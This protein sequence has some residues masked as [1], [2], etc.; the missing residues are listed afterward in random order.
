MDDLICGANDL[1]EVI[2]L[3]NTIHS[4]LAAAGFVLRK[5]SS[6]SQELLGQIKED[7]LATSFAYSPA[8][9]HVVSILGITW[10][11]DEDQFRIRINL[12]PPAD[13]TVI[14]K[15][16]LLSC[17]S[18]IFDPLGFVEPVTITG[19]LIIQR[20]WLEDNTWGNPAGKS[21]A[22]DFKNYYEDIRKFSFAIPR[23]YFAKTH[24]HQSC[25]LIGF[26]DASDKAY[27]AVVY[28]RSVL[29][30]KEV[31][32]TIVASQSRIAPIKTVSV[33]WLEVQA[34]T[35]LASLMDRI[36]QN[37]IIDSSNIYRFTDSTVVL[38]WL[39]K[40]PNNWK[41]YVTNRVIKITN[42]IPFTQWFYV[43]TDANPSDLATCGINVESFCKTNM[44]LRGPDFLYL[45]DPLQC[46]PIP[47]LDT[48]LSLEQRKVKV[49]FTVF[50]NS[51]LI[52]RFSSYSQLMPVTE[53][54]HRYK[55]R[56][57]DKKKFDTIALT[58]PEY[59]HAHFSI[60]R[61]IQNSYFATDIARLEVQRPLKKKSHLAKFNPF[62]D[63][64]HV[65]RVGGR[66][67]GSFS[68]K[69]KHSILLPAKSHFI[70]LF[71]RHLHKL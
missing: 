1:A 47:N 57:V 71:I 60:I 31:V 69:K 32:C 39:S 3:Q 54:M 42:L 44:W 35:L 28:M 15:R 55:L 48:Q 9:S 2:E 63:E 49:S 10:I 16:K 21:I 12:Q 25:Q 13:N 70:L 38:C 23:F 37:L 36:A 58:K 6:N 8:T 56:V 4:T 46:N 20:L 62:L 24:N 11:P 34:T 26:T 22:Q 53:R 17:M 40:P 65:L 19:K 27:C 51:S 41:P 30:D 67:I 45:E 5:Y 59:D 33:P 14:T 18:Q 64:H 50:E 61:I 68:T 66:I 29:P 52:A 43:P 7:L